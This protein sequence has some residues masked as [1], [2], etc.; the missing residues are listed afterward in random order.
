MGIEAGDE[1]AERITAVLQQWGIGDRFVVIDLDG[2]AGTPEPEE[3]ATL[4][5][6]L[7]DINPLPDNALLQATVTPH[8]PE[9]GA[10]MGPT[11]G[12]DTDYRYLSR[13]SVLLGTDFRIGSF[14]ESCFSQEVD[15]AR[16]ADGNNVA[17]IDLEYRDVRS[18]TSMELGD[19]YAM[20]PIELNQIVPSPPA[21]TPPVTSVTW[22]PHAGSLS[23]GGYR[24]CF[25]A[26]LMLDCGKDVPAAVNAPL[27]N[28]EFVN[29]LAEAFGAPLTEVGMIS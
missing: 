27:H 12:P 25:R 17:D 14:A 5:G 2:P 23:G 7:S 3:D 28:R 19:Y 1:T 22:E 21:V 6:F 4:L 20:V 16:D 13:I 29:E 9:V 15:P 10:V 8:G 26:G 11:S 18:P 24:G